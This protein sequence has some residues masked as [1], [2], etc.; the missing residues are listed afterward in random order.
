LS[1]KTDIKTAPQ[2]RIAPAKLHFGLI[3]GHEV[4][5]ISKSKVR[6][7]CPSEGEYIYG[8]EL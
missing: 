6:L 3:C 2:E 1:V 7:C 4:R 5:P 8:G